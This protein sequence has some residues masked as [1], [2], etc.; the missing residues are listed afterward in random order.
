[1]RFE[2]YGY[3]PQWQMGCAMYA[4][5]QFPRHYSKSP[6]IEIFRVVM[7]KIDVSKCRYPINICVFLPEVPS[8][9]EAGLMIMFSYFTYKKILDAM[10]LVHRDHVLIAIEA[11]ILKAG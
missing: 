6:Y 3:P 1:M 5:T 8:R 10:W 9:H 7:F 2:E 4:C 11:D